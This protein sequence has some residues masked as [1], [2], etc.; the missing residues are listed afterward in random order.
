MN[1]FKN[2]IITIFTQHLLKNI[3]N[4]NKNFIEFYTSLLKFNYLS[5]L[6]NNSALY[7]INYL[8]FLL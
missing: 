4:V 1:L 6:K 7:L 2:L 5:F 8:I 3:T